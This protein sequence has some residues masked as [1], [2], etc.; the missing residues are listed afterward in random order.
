METSF[1]EVKEGNLSELV[2]DFVLVANSLY[3]DDPNW[4]P[5]TLDDA[6]NSIEKPETNGERKAFIAYVNNDPVARLIASYDDSNSMVLNENTGFFSHF[7]TINDLDV[8][9]S[10]FE[11]ANSWFRSRNIHKIIGPMTPKITDP[12]GLLLK[13]EGKPLFGMPYTK[14]Y[15]IDILDSLSFTKSMNMYE[16]IIKLEKPYKKLEKVAKYVTRKYPQ[17]KIKSINLNDLYNEIDRIVTV[18]NNAWKENWGFIPIVTDDFYEVFKQVLPFYKEDYCKIVEVDGEC[19]G[20][21]M[22][23]PDLNN[24]TKN[25][26]FRAFFIG[27]LPEYRNKGIE[28]LLLSE[29]LNNVAVKYNIDYIHVAWV[30]E[31]NMKWRKE[32]EKIVG[33]GNIDYKLYTVLEKKLVNEEGQIL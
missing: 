21:Q 20:F 30:L 8:V 25:N 5:F 17:V 6:K 12:R 2:E 11:K 16:Y 26:V 3:K 32:I 13:G 24:V 10:L 7:E 31:N 29:C 14:K 15:Y 23:M 1:I 27:V 28:G 9:Q 22:I 18:Y 19:I 33:K 4:V